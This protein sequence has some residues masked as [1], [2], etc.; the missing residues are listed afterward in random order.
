MAGDSMPPGRPKRNWAGDAPEATKQIKIT[1]PEA[2]R[3][4]SLYLL[5][6]FSVALLGAIVAFIAL[7]FTAKSRLHYL[8]IPITEYRDRLYPVNPWAEQDGAALQALFSADNNV[9]PKAEIAYEGQ[10][11]APLLRE[12]GGLSSQDAE[13]VVVHLS[14]LARAVGGEIY[15]L[16]ADA[17]P[18]SRDT[19]IPLTTVLGAVADCKAPNKL[20]ILDL[21]KPLADPRL[22]VLA[23]DV[24]TQLQKAL[25]QREANNQLP[26][27]VL[28]PC[29]R[30]QVA[31]PWEDRQ[32][33]AFGY[34]LAEGLRGHADGAA[35]QAKKEGRVSVRELADY[36]KDNVERWAVRY[37]NARQTP[38]LYGQAK[39]FNLLEIQTPPPPEPAPVATAYPAWLL[40]SWQKIDGWWTSGGYRNAPGVYR[41]AEAAVLRAEKRWRGGQDAARIEKALAVD[42]QELTTRYDEAQQAARRPAPRSLALETARGRTADPSISPALKELLAKAGE[43]SA[44]KPED[45][46]AAEGKMLDGFL[47]QSA[48]KEIVKDKEGKEVEKPSKDTL[49]D[50]PHYDFAWSAFDIVAGDENPG[51]DKVRVL[52]DVLRRHQA[53]ETYLEAFLLRRLGVLAADP[54]KKWRSEVVHALVRAAQEREIASA[55]DPN[56]LPWV[57]GLIDDANAKF[58]Q[59]EALVFMGGPPSTM[60]KARGLLQAANMQYQDATNLAR[61]LEEADQRADQ[62]LALLPGLAPYLAARPQ[63][64]ASL[65]ADWI[66]AAREANALRQLLGRPPEQPLNAIGQL[67]RHLEEL[68]RAMNNLQRST[69]PESVQQLL[70]P[71][72][73]TPDVNTHLEIQALL[74]CARLPAADRKALWTGGKEMSD[75]LNNRT[76]QGGPSENARAA[77]RGTLVINWLKAAGVGGAVEDLERTTLREAIDSPSPTAWEKLGEQ[78]RTTVAIE[79]PRQFGQLLLTRDLAGLDRLGRLLISVGVA[80][81]E[82]GRLLAPA[83]QQRRQAIQAYYSWLAD[84][85]QAQSAALTGPPAAFFA[86]IATEYRQFAR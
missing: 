56:V 83:A 21:G 36:V 81:A 28:T 17:L 62:A 16:P 39:D 41:Q 71:T 45:A 23:N 61:V 19:W 70:K 13:T 27:W 49:K 5:G 8:A 33:S 48:S 55:A 14:G 34:Y 32:H 52:G 3:R 15:I 69:T 74:E 76:V 46:K 35:P 68:S 84:R 58:S 7:V 1:T 86:E 38:R 57:R 30:D 73:G 78:L 79:I 29:Q 77:Q 51:A 12:L 63:A 54:D 47:K 67:Q 50:K 2:K 24:A 6:I 25:E 59:G 31:L 85:Y 65:E 20:L 9:A 10:S 82:G 22:G 18:D 60:E 37:R 26:F 44:L 80:P 66:S 42:L 40:K 64:D 43:L 53:Q 4:K 11:K 75:K 72:P